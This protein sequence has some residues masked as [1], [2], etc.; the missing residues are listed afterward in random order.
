MW[1]F[2]RVSNDGYLRQILCRIG[3]VAEQHRG[4]VLRS[5]LPDPVRHTHVKTTR[6]VSVWLHIYQ[7]VGRGDHHSAK[8]RELIEGEGFLQPNACVEIL[9]TMFL[10]G[11]TF[12]VLLR[13]EKL[14]RTR[15]HPF[16]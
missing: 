15:L 3:E 16:G 14:S 7:P 11:I 5:G 9:F 2:G 13:P 6:D 4:S 10:F 8:L 1:D 12:L